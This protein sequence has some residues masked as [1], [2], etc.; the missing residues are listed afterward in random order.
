MKNILPATALFLATLVAPS[1]AEAPGPHAAEFK[2]FHAAFLAAAK[3]NDRQKLADLIA[4]PV[5]DWAVETQGN[6]QEGPIKDRAE[7]LRR[8]DTLFT[9]S[10]RAHAQGAK[11][12]PL[13]DGRY[14]IVWDDV[15]TEFSF[16]FG[17][18][19]G[20]GYR[21]TSYSIGPR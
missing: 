21:I 2:T 12:Q 19:T 16:E 8:Y 7:F 1:F 11:P 15:D 14:M 4:F 9:K 17:Y 10:M 5:E 20:T 3:A 13:Q 18:A 6:V